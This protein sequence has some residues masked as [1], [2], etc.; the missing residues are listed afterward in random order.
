MH[1]ASLELC[2]ELYELSGWRDTYFYW[3]ND[4]QVY[5]NLTNEVTERNK[6]FE[7]Y[8]YDLGYLLRRLQKEYGLH[9][10][11]A[12]HAELKMPAALPQW[13]NKYVAYTATMMQRDYP[14]ADIPEDALC[15]LA[16]QLFK[17][18]I[19]TREGDRN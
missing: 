3:Q 15:K 17:Q 6:R 9:V 4:N 18:G 5:T 1:V 11:V 13:N 14:I 12:Y 8:A 2:Q 19:L 7:C 10:S 16:I